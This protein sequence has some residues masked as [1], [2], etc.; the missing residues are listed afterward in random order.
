MRRILFLLLLATVPFLGCW[1]EGDITA[2]DQ[3]VSSMAEV[4]S[5]V[6]SA[7][8]VITVHPNKKCSLN[9]SA[10][11][12]ALNS[13]QPGDVVFL[14]DGDATTVDTYCVSEGIVVLN[15]FS[16]TLMGEGKDNTI[17]QAVRGPGKAPFYFDFDSDY[18]PGPCCTSWPTVL[19][20]EYPVDVTVRGLTI[21][22]EDP[23]HPNTYFQFVAVWGGDHKAVF[24]NLR[25]H[26]NPTDPEWYVGIHAMAGSETGFP[27]DGTGNVLVKDVEA[28]DVFYGVI[29][30][31]YGDGSTFIIEDLRTTRAVWGVWGQ[32]LASGL[33][34][35]GSTFQ[36]SGLDA[37]F[38]RES[39]NVSISGN[40]LTMSARTGVFLLNVSNGTVSGNIIKDQ[41]FDVWWKSGIYFRHGVH[42]VT[43]TQ[44]KFENL[45]GGLG[46]AIFLRG[47]DS[48]GYEVTNNWIHRN[49]FTQ[50]GLPGW[51]ADTPNGPGAIH[52]GPRAF[53]NEVFEPD[54]LVGS[55]KGLCE[56]VWDETDDESTS[57]YD[58]E[59]KIHGWQPCKPVDGRAA[60]SEETDLESGL[61]GG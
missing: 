46:Q 4:A 28:G 8:S 7:S 47:F 45:T 3:P 31:W 59:N 39:S 22:A 21:A 9:A 55:G 11:Q 37:V 56:M 12:L 44:N 13:A 34:I 36:E 23:G 53:G 26:G 25:F 41:H 57:Q 35:N 61:L 52:L 32:G 43:V 16:G 60:Q 1:T 5:N 6:T 10:I 33:Q 19:H 14:T 50:S 29:P 54:Y 15:G 48:P 30:M 40:T 58:G 49:D 2:L 38:L 51:T 42:E 18:I 24:E 27:L 20:F 17:I